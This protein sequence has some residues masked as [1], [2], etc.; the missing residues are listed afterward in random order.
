AE[1]LVGAAGGEQSPV[2]AECGAQHVPRV[3]AVRT[4][5]FAPDGRAL[6][7]GDDAGTL[8]RWAV[9]VV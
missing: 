7:T 9:P 1:C 8:G 2:R 6:F 5:A 4:V 3:A